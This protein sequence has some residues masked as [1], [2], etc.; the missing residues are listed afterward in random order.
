[1]GTARMVARWWRVIPAE[2]VDSEGL[3]YFSG[4][5][6]MTAALDGAEVLRGF[7]DG[8]REVMEK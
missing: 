7:M 5:L 4:I 8:V 1:M 6:D 2:A 3:A